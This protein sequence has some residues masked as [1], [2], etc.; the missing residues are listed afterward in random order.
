MRVPPSGL[1]VLAVVSIFTGFKVKFLPFRLCPFIFTISAVLILVGHSRIDEASK[2]H[3][4]EEH[5][6][7]TRKVNLFNT[8]QSSSG[9]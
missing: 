5:T 2:N 4:L 9:W 8:A 3:Y 6:Y 1:I 7:D